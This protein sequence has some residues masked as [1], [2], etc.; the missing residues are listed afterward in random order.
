MRHLAERAGTLLATAEKTFNGQ[1]LHMNTVKYLRQKHIQVLGLAYIFLGG[2][3][4]SV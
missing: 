4:W 2:R 3:A 1:C